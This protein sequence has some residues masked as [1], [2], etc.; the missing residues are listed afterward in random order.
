MAGSLLVRRPDWNR[1]GPHVPVWFLRRLR[2]LDPRLV[3]QFTPPRSL[4][5]PRGVPPRIYPNGIWDICKR[6]RRS[7]FLHPV[8]T[9]SLADS[10]GYYAPPGANTL[11]LLGTAMKL[12]RAGRSK[13]LED[14]MDR[15]LEEI[16]SAQEARSVERLHS[17]LQ[18]FISFRGSRQW[19]NRVFLRKEIPGS[20]LVP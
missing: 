13:V 12:H 16:N 9:W 20:G 11:K 5:D 4:K 15:A 6:M 10:E 3:L 18:K 2:R 8:A 19:N 14:K 17:A 1:R 7:G